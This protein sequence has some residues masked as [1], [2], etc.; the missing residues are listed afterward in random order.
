MD[1]RVIV[2]FGVGI[3]LLMAGIRDK[4]PVQLIQDAFDASKANQSQV[5]TGGAAGV[6]R[7]AN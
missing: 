3:T 2:L 6:S 7:R 1:I 5:G 4:S